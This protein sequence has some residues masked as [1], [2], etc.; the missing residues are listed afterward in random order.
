VLALVL[1]LLDGS[2]A[3]GELSLG[4]SSCRF[5]GFLD[6]EVK[7]NFALLRRDVNALRFS[8]LGAVV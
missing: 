1:S 2:V 7:L 4:L 8:G 5:E 3:L 6:H